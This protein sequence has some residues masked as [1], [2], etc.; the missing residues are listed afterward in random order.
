MIGNVEIAKE[1]IPYTKVEGNPK[2]RRFGSYLHLAAKYGQPAILK[3]LIFQGLS[4]RLKDKEG[5]SVYDLLKDENF[6]VETY[7]NDQQ[8][9]VKVDGDEGKKCKEEMLKFME[10]II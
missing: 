7:S 5:R 4:L 2:G 1:I 9:T 10:R 8:C 6:Q 3:M